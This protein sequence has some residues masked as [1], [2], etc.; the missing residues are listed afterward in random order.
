MMPTRAPASLPRSSGMYFRRHAGAP[1]VLTASAS[2]GVFC[3]ICSS[4]SAALRR[5]DGVMRSASACT[6]AGTTPVSATLFA[7]ASSWLHTWLRLC[8]AAAFR[9]GGV[10]L[11]RA[12]RVSGSSAFCATTASAS[13]L[14]TAAT[15]PSAL[16]MA[17]HSEWGESAE[18][19]SATSV[20]SS[21]GLQITAALP[22]LL[23][24]S[25][26]SVDTA[27][28]L[29]AGGVCALRSCSRSGGSAPAIMTLCALSVVLRATAESTPSAAACT[30][31][32]SW[33]MLCTTESRTPHVTMT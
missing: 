21:S 27:L 14:L 15:L 31:G 23:W 33:L 3:T 1:A 25:E 32:L 30:G 18:S 29:T 12:S 2:S 19:M 8:S 22:S 10:L 17:L 7:R 9:S 16:T 4:S 20:D 28:S 24:M 11:P 6:A 13:T 5:I 26:S